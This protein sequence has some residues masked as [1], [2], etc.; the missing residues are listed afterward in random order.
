[1]QFFFLVWLEQIIEWMDRKGVPHVFRR[2][3]DEHDGQLR[4]FLAQLLCCA[5]AVGTLHADIQKNDIGRPGGKKAEK[6]I[7]ALKTAAENR[8]RRKFFFQKALQPFCVRP[9][10]FHNHH[11]QIHDDAPL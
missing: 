9:E 3:S 8:F 11:S 4:V 5:D 2:G 10:V 1:M 7:S 6:I